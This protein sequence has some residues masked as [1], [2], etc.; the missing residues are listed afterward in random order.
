M[1]GGLLDS[2]MAL[3]S[4]A[5]TRGFARAR[6]DEGIRLGGLAALWLSLLL[7]AYWWAADR[8]FQDLGGWE[9]GLTSAGR[10]TGLISADLLLAQVLLMARLPLLERAL[11]RT[12]WPASTAGSGFLSSTSCSSTSSSSP[13]ATP[14]VGESPSR[15]PCGTW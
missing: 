9:T 10:L 14:A 15:R 4:P 5:R 8:G 12:G 6:W 1:T 13:G 7:V 2:S 3:A 11:A